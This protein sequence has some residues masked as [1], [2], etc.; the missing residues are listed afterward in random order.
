MASRLLTPTWVLAHV[1]VAGLA[2]LFVSLGLWQLDRLEER[3][4]INRIGSERF[5]MDPVPF[6]TIED[7]DGADIEYRR[8]T[9]TG[10]V[11]PSGE[12]LIRSQVHLGTAGYHLIVPVSYRG[13]AEVL[14]NRGWVPLSTEIGSMDHQPDED[15]TISLMGWVHSTQERPSLGPADPETGVLTVMSRVD[16]DRIRRQADPGVELADVY[17]VEMGERGTEPP[18]AVEPPDF[19][20]EGPHLSYA[21]QWF[22]FTA[23]LV[24][25]YVFLARRRSRDQVGSGDFARSGTTS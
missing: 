2:A 12:V 16:I 21:V 8:V 6:E 23:V 1:A 11:R 24:I 3:R 7:E 14:V 9:V 20:D 5:S 25:G 13:S 4:G 17:V 22:G 18:F 19:E 10:R 15:G